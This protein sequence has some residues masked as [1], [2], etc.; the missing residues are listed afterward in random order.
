MRLLRIISMT[1]GCIFLVSAITGIQR[2]HL[3]GQ[4]GFSLAMHTM[5]TRLIALVIGLVFVAWFFAL[6][7]HA[8]WGIWGTNIVFIGILCACLWQGVERAIKRDTAAAKMWSIGS[9]TALALV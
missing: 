2:L 9:Q 7:Q 4:A 6:R 8:R 5:A 1:A 3:S